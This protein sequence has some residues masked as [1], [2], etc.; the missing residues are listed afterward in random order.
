M[1]L[2][3]T[4]LRVAETWEQ[5]ECFLAATFPA[6]RFNATRA[7]GCTTT[8]QKELRWTPLPLPALSLPLDN[9]PGDK[10]GEGC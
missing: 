7:S 6:S 3:V 1:L 5:F 9:T 8:L 10:Y 4:I 2:L